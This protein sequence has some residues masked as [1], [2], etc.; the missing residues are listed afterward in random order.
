[1]GELPFAILSCFVIERTV[2]MDSLV[3]VTVY[4]F[5]PVML[6]GVTAFISS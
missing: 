5:Q 6:F 2:L 3:Q 1:V 4:Y